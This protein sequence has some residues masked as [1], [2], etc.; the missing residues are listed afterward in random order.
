[1][2][3]DGMSDSDDEV[4]WLEAASEVLEAAGFVRTPPEPDHD[5]TLDMEALHASLLELQSD[6]KSA[7]ELQD[8]MTSA[9]EPLLEAA[10]T[11]CDSSRREL[12]APF[13]DATLR[14]AYADCPCE[15]LVITFGG[16]TAA[17]NAKV[18]T[19][20]VAQHE[21]VGSC[22]RLGV[23]HALFVRDLLQSWYLRRPPP[24]AAAAIAEDPCM[25]EPCFDCYG[26]LIALLRVEIAA[27]QAAP[28]PNPNPNPDPNPNPNP[29]PSRYPNPN[30]NPSPNPNPNP[31]LTR[32]GAS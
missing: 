23:K 31:T 2:S 29:N 9:P 13:A 1:M 26:P 24:C 10:G 28:D 27:L 7:P 11:S 30:P 19:P 3:T 8:F 12:S 14:R 18:L 15:T 32:S 21:L 25:D 5:L 17:G 16:L 20:G 22:S 4:D 6:L